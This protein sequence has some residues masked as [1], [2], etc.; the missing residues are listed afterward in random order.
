MSFLPFAVTKSWTRRGRLDF[1]RSV[2]TRSKTT[3]TVAIDFPARGS[4]RTTTALGPVMKIRLA[5]TLACLLMLTSHSAF[6]A[7]G[8]DDP[9]AVAQSF[10][11]KHTSFSSENPAKIKSIIT[12]RFFHA[13]DREFKCAQGEVCAIE[14]D[15]WTDAQDGKIGKPV[16]FATA[17]NSGVE[18]KISMTYPFI[19]DTTHHEQKHATLVLQR[20]TPT[21]CW[22]IDDLIDPSGDSLVQYVEKWHK[23]FGDA[24]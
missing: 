16:V 11:E 10:F 19:L 1:Y 22:L 3:I 13:L 8:S 14:S 6:A 4:R 18:A 20:S 9:V 17:S 21:A 7:C 15:P 5:T 2:G 24:K 12:P 23:E